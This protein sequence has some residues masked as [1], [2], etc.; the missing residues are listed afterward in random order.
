MRYKIAGEIWE[1]DT[2]IVEIINGFSDYEYQEYVDEV[3]NLRLDGIDSFCNHYSMLYVQAEKIYTLQVFAEELL[4]KEKLLL[5]A[6]VVIVKTK[7]F[8][9]I[10]GPGEGKSTLLEL[11]VTRFGHNCVEIIADDRAVIALVDSHLEVWNTPWSKKGV[12]C[13]ENGYKIDGILFLEKSENFMIYDIDVETSLNIL[14]ELYPRDVWDKV[15]ELAK[16]ILNECATYKFDN[17]LVNFDICKFEE[18]L[19]V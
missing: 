16:R 18:V 13:K 1:Y 7:C 19:K 17:N 4:Q 10:G 2:N 15:A 12:C 3:I 8:V 14:S 9:I 11:L 5:H 6:G